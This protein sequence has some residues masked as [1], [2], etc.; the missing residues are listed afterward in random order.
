[1]TGRGVDHLADCPP[2][3]TRTARTPRRPP[4]RCPPSAACCAVARARRR[5]PRSPSSPSPNASPSPSLSPSPAPSRLHR[6]CSPTRSPPTTRS[7]PPHRRPPRPR[8]TTPRRRP[9]W[10]PLPSPPR[11]APRT[12]TRRPP[13]TTQG[14]HGSA[15]A[16][17]PCPRS[18]HG[19]RPPSP[20]P[21]SGCWPSASPGW[22]MQGCELVRGTTSCGGVGLL[23]L[24]VILAAMVVLGAVMLKAW[25]IADA[26]STSVLAVGLIA[27]I[28]LLLL[29][30]VLTVHLDAAGHP[31]GRRGD[32]RALA[33]GHGEVRR[34]RRPA[35][36]TALLRG[37]RRPARRSARRSAPHPCAGCRC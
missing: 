33:R 32:V 2:W 10:T 37:G 8:P 23:M 17:S 1:M 25:G 4:W 31:A 18:P 7:R 36:P 35:D 22:A 26:T 24:L 19:P 30:D 9:R 13:R 5:L 28:C 15:A 3:P 6:C 27:V 20:A 16:G 11:P 34:G 12:T 14:P 29:I 21:W